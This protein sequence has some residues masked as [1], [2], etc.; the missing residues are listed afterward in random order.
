MEND[1]SNKWMLV[2]LIIFILMPATSFCY[3]NTNSPG[4]VAEKQSNVTR[5]DLTLKYDVDVPGKTSKIRL[6]VALPSTLSDRQKIVQTKFST[7]PTNI[8]VENGNRYAEFI[9]DSPPKHFSVEINVEAEVYRY[10]LVAAREKGGENRVK[11]PNFSE[12]LQSEKF[13]EKDDPLIQQVA[14]RITAS[15][16]ASI[17]KAIYDY[18]ISNMD[19]SGYNEKPLGAA[20][21]IR[22][23]KGDCTEY[24]TLLAALC[25]AKKIPARVVH[26]YT[27]ER[28]TTPKH[29]W[30]EVYLKECGWV[31]FDPVLAPKKKPEDRNM[32]F[33]HL[34]R[35]Y[36]YSHYGM[37]NRRYRFRYWGDK[38]TVQDSIEIKKSS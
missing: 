9:V 14:A 16:E 31:P 13:I 30:A 24:A 20:V 26:G 15:S 18:V 23:K 32:S 17:V 11:E 38:V 2:S 19:Y 28:H 36:L 35:T 1:N 7:E 27:V 34:K 8:L 3:T 12:Y 5:V 6:V 25:R 22:E 10:D 33:H 37:N 21:A 4:V 29:A